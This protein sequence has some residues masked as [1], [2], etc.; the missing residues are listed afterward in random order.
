MHLDVNS[1]GHIL[2][3]NRLNNTLYFFYKNIDHYKVAQLKFEPEF[4][5]KKADSSDKYLIIQG[6]EQA[7]SGS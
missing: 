3:I 4:R 6:F 5:I 7:D 2:M 1:H